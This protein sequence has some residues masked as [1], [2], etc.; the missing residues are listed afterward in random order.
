MSH[1]RVQ[2]LSIVKR[3][4]GYA[5]RGRFAESNVIPM[6][7]ETHETKRRWATRAEVD[8]FLTWHFWDGNLQGGRSEWA[9]R[10]D[11]AI[12]LARRAD[13]KYLSNPR[14][15]DDDDKSR[16]YGWP[17]DI[18]NGVIFPAARDLY[19]LWKGA[20]GKYAIVDSNDGF[21]EKITT[22]RHGGNTIH[23]Q[24]RPT[25]WKAVD[26]GRLESKIALSESGYSLKFL[27]VTEAQVANA[28]KECNAESEYFYP[29]DVASRCYGVGKP[30]FDKH[31]EWCVG[32]YPALLN[33]GKISDTADAA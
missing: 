16:R 5:Y 31:W 2:N 10:N 17:V 28:E 12:L 21:V 19:A 24:A 27:C 20:S 4:D 8:S 1:T 3:K 25:F 23:R 26:M 13:V 33:G 29:S 11:I 7:Y 9:V 18:M 32:K 6:D 14:D 22:T 15:W 30:L